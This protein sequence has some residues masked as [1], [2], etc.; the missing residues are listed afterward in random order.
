MVS[1]NA[2]V[3][4]AD[5]PSSTVAGPGDASACPPEGVQ[6]GWIA[7]SPGISGCVW[8]G[9]LRRSISRDAGY[10]ARGLAL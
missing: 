8:A 6:Q 7:D 5:A 10:G 3:P 2:C 9:N 1:V 4:V